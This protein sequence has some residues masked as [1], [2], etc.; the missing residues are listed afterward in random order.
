MISSFE[1]KPPETE[2]IEKAPLSK[3]K[4]KGKDKD[5]EKQFANNYFFTTLLF[6]Y[7]HF[8]RAAKI[9]PKA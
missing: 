9:D 5:K 6:L 1:E 3:G 4:D 2:K 7:G 8:F